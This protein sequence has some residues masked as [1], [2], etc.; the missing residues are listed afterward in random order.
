MEAQ[1]SG[2]RKRQQISKANRAMFLWVA[3]A[4]VVVG[5]CLVMAL[6]LGRQIIFGEKVIAEKSRT[7]TTLEK[8]LAAVDQLR[9]NVR[10]LETNE[11]LKSV[12]LKDGDPVLQSVLDALPAG[13]NST[14]LGSSLQSRLLDG[15]NGVTL[16]SIKVDPVQ[17]IETDAASDVTASSE[18][19]E[20]A[21]SF[22]FSVSVNSNNPGAL[23][24]ILQRI[25][26]SIRPINITSVAVESQGSRLV[27]SAAG[28]AYYEP[29]KTIELTEKVVRP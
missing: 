13:A 25:E 23:R 19:I 8:N 20:N 7:A 22:T 16:D 27:L 17:G 5:F 9:Q 11:N 2:L 12:R 1:G 14:A 29:A 6:F 21:I 3:G 4:S 26:R 18:A 15:V 24:E 28:H 10:V